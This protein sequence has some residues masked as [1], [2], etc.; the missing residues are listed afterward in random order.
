LANRTAG[1]TSRSAAEAAAGDGVEEQPMTTTLPE[2]RVDQAEVRVLLQ[3]LYLELTA[4]C[5]AAT[6]ALAE[7]GRTADRD[8]DDEADAGAKT[9]EREH[10][11]SVV[12]TI[13]ERLAQ[14]QRALERLDAGTYG[15]CES[16]HETITP[17]RLAAFPSATLCVECKRA[18]ERRS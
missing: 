17:E 8:G 2:G 1:T 9:S 11:L 14:A 10:Q 5:E 12:A 13:R 4:E 15:R 7:F 3:G 16:C 18:D 6:A